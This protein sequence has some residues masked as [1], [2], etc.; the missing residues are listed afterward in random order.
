VSDN[1]NHVVVPDGP[2]KVQNPT[3]ATRKVNLLSVHGDLALSRRDGPDNGHIVLLATA[4]RASLT[5]RE[6]LPIRESKSP[7]SSELTV[8][9]L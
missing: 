6:C 3:T 9:A 2:R 4:R 1:L 8:R 7:V 5:I